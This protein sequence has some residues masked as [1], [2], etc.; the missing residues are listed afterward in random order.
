MTS[1]SNARELDRLRKARGDAQEQFARQMRLLEQ[2]EATAGEL[3]KITARWHTQL[4]A[5]IELAGSSAT[6]ATLSGLSKANLETA[7]RDVEPADIAVAI[8]AAK[9]KTPR[10]RKPR[11]AATSSRTDT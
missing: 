8:A 11:D 3:D 1:T 2:I 5:L 4:A 6:A 10:R 7:A 9:P